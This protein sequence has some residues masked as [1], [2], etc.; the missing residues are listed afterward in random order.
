MR[1]KVFTF[2][3]LHF[4]LILLLVSCGNRRSPTGGPVD[5]IKPEI[6]YTIPME[7]EQIESNEIII[8]FSRPMQRTS[9]M[10]GLHISPPQTNKRATWKRNNLHL[11]LDNDLRIDS[12]L[13]VFLN[14]SIRCE[15]NNTFEDH[16]ILVFRNG[17]L[18][19]NNLSG[20]ITH[21]LPELADR[22]VNFTLLDS[23]SLVVFNKSISGNN[24]SF[25]YLNPGK[26]TLTAYIDRNNNNRFDFAID[27]SYT[28][29]FELPISH[30]IDMHLAVADTLMPNY[31]SISS[32][33]NN[34]VNIVYNKDLLRPPHIVIHNDSTKTV[35]DIIH[36]EFLD[37]RSFLVTAPMDTLTHRIQIIS[38]LDDKENETSRTSSF[39][40]NGRPDTL[41]PLITEIHP[42]NGT[43]INTVSPEITITFN[44][45][46]FA[47][48]ISITLREIET[49]NNIHLRPIKS[50][51][52]TIIYQ[53][54]HNLREFNSYQLIVDQYTKDIVGNNLETELTIQFIVAP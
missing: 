54:I 17:E 47:N 4:T 45:I 49:N 12:N 6:L 42:R 15:R 3:I 30:T 44:K 50:A 13:L 43:V 31:S 34:Q 14:R 38:L 36:H 37:N 23:D 8:A 46:M 32:P 40:S 2:Y 22:D 48:D 9:V 19:R 35:I 24:F 28:T 18:Q 10:S 33:S 29:V 20:F 11:R 41:P 53:P 51:G 39:F 7:F 26:Y 1:F 25:D 16:Q 52:F 5:T 21:D 27:P